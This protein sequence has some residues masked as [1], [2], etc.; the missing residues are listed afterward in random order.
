[1]KDI[2][3]KSLGPFC[4]WESFELKNCDA[5]YIFIANK[6]SFYCFFHKITKKLWFPNKIPN[7][8]IATSSCAC[9]M[10]KSVFVNYYYKLTHWKKSNTEIY[11]IHDDMRY[12]M[13]MIARSVE[14]NEM[15]SKQFIRTAARVRE[16]NVH[17]IHQKR[18]RKMFWFFF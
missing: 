2:D 12:N 4:P 15:R 16:R 1:M 11:V 5:I 10:L 9:G 13:W 14:E 17:N 7:K 6:H 3:D 8:L 18:M